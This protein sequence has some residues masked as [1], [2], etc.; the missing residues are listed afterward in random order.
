MLLKS[1]PTLTVSVRY[2]YNI[3]YRYCDVIHTSVNEAYLA[4][5]RT[6]RTGADPAYYETSL[7]VPPSSQPPA[8]DSL[9]E[10]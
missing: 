7:S 10:N 6:G 8:E 1:I 3:I 9:Y 4:V 2:I 5:K